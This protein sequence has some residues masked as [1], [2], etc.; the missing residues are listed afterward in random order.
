[1]GINIKDS[2]IGNKNKVNSDNHLK[3]IE[4]DWAKIGV[5]VA[6]IGIVVAIIVGWEEIKLFILK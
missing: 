6:I 2:I 5:I 1:M 4:T 3:P